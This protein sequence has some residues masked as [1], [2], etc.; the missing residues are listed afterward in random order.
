MIDVISIRCEECD[1]IACFGFDKFTHCA[2]HK[3]E[4]MI[5]VKKSK[6]ELCCIAPQYSTYKLCRKCFY[7]T[8][9]TSVKNFN[10]KKLLIKSFLNT[11]FKNTE[12]KQD[13]VIENIKVDFIIGNVAIFINTL[14]YDDADKSLFDKVYASDNL[15]IKNLN[16]NIIR[17]NPNKYKISGKNSTPSPFT[18]NKKDSDKLNQTKSK[19][20]NNRLTLL[21]SNINKLLSTNT[22]L[23]KVVYVCFNE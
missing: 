23:D 20:W 6:C 17:F 1:T 10:A 22:I 12:I 18:I 2:E 3:K 21:N 4:G 19:E 15:K 8:D 7:E 14:V 9:T 13:S 11:T 5:N 16:Y